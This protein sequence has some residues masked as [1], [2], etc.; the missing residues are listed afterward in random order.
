MGH[1]QDQPETSSAQGL[2]TNKK[3]ALVFTIEHAN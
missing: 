3:H 2:L 1:E